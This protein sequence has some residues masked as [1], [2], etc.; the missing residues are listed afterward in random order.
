MHARK[1]WLGLLRE[2]QD[3]LEARVAHTTVISSGKDL[4]SLVSMEDQLKATEEHRR[5]R[6]DDF[7]VNAERLYRRTPEG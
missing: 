4:R 2:E 6:P 1:Q 3:V 5:L 7:A